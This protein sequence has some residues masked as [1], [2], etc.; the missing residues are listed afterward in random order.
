MRHNVDRPSLYRLHP[1]TGDL[2]GA[3][4]RGTAGEEEMAAP[5]LDLQCV[6]SSAEEGK[7]TPVQVQIHEGAPE[8]IQGKA[9]AFFYL[10]FHVFTCFQLCLLLN[11][12]LPK[13]VR[14]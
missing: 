14:D 9:A 10:C 3:A 12:Y 2:S 5:E 13:H 7:T 1:G 11:I 4:R 8:S 6:A